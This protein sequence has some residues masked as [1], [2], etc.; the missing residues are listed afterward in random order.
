MKSLLRL[1]DER[2]PDR[3]EEYLDMNCRDYFALNPE[4]E[5]IQMSVE[6]KEVSG[7]KKRDV[8]IA[9]AAGLLFMA[10]YFTLENYTSDMPRASTSSDV[11]LQ[12]KREEEQREAE[13]ER[14]KKKS[15][16]WDREHLSDR[17][18]YLIHGRN[19]GE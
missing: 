18:Y 16:P 7:T 9:I 6:K 1:C 10:A 8:V 15:E 11:R 17:D 3:Y 4:K 5:E 13:Y 19:K 14:L 12:K 2:A